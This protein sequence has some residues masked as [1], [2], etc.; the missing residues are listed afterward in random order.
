MINPNIF[1]EIP[2]FSRYMIKLDGS[3]LSKETGELMSVSYDKQGRSK[4]SIYRDDGKRKTVGIY[5][6]KAMTFIGTPD[7]HETMVINHIDGDPSNDDLDNLE[8]CTQQENVH[9]AGYMGLTEKSKPIQVK[10]ILTGIVLDFPTFKACAEDLNISKDAV[11]WRVSRGEDRVDNLFNQYRL[12]TDNGLWSVPRVWDCGV[13][14]RN[15]ITGEIVTFTSQSELCQ[16]YSV[17]PAFISK[18][19][20][21][22]DQSLFL[23][24]NY[25]YQI[26]INK[27][28]LTWIDYLD[29]YLTFERTTQTRFVVM[30]NPETESRKIWATATMAAETYGYKKNV[31][32]WRCR[33]HKLEPW[34]DGLIC[35]YLFY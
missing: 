4:I 17:S 19:L 7:N 15:V 18:K 20:S 25:L 13:K 28:D 12:L 22:S 30:Y 32:L 11:S 14:L 5:R 23:M 27:P 10:N 29:P 2:Y 26:D 9:H 8:W 31:A 24:G 34:H 16:E 21:R 1:Y 3:L 35:H 6:L 33:H